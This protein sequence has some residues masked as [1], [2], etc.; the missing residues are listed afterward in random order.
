M[1]EVRVER[2][3]LFDT[4]TNISLNVVV[5]PDFGQ[6]LGDEARRPAKLFD[7]PLPTQV[8]RV[9]RFWLRAGIEAVFRPA[10]DT[11]RPVR[12]RP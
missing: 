1:P 9:L 8:G 5:P 7:M 6:Q 10:I 4:A 3:I 11:R 12:S 2:G